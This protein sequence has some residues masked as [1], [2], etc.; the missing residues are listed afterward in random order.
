MTHKSFQRILYIFLLLVSTFFESALAQELLPGQAIPFDEFKALAQAQM[1]TL[2]YQ[3]HLFY[4]KQGRYPESLKELRESPF[5]FIEI[6][7]I[8]SGYPL[9]QIPFSPKAGDFVAGEET[10]ISSTPL[11]GPTPPGAPPTRVTF[12]RRVN[13]AKVEYP[14]PGDLLYF[15]EG[16]SLQLVIYDDTG[17]WHE[18]FLSSPYNFRASTVKPIER[19]TDK[20]DFLVLALG[21]HLELMLP[22]MIAKLNFIRKSGET[23]PQAIRRN[24]LD[25]FADYARLLGLVY[26]NPLK[27][28]ELMP[29]DYYSPGDIAILPQL[30]PDSELLY[31]L[32][33]GRVRTIRQMSDRQV[34]KAEVETMKKRDRL[35]KNL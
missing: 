3:I 17:K 11:R 23:S 28:R 19:P 24:L 27:R 21:T 29:V 16:D 15:T 34:Y 33:G 25:K 35:I 2:H 31:F 12:G 7:N 1:D 32:E 14:N 10:Q 22:Q 30:M 8:Y 26:L 20:G 9:E 5:F 4:M 18:V 13:P 6:T